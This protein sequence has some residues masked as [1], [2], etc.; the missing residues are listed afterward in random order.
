MKYTLDQQIL[1]DQVQD[2]FNAGYSCAQCVCCSFAAQLNLSQKELYRIS[3][4]FGGGMA[5]GEVCGAVAGAIMV[6]GLKSASRN[7]DTKDTYAK[8]YTY[9]QCHKFMMNFKNHTGSLCCRDLIGFDF[10]KI[11]DNQNIVNFDRNLYKNCSK[12][13]RIATQ[14]L[15]EIIN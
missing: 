14:V 3:A 13:I 12:Y 4:G 9:Q 7:A 5:S 2:L 10:G 11:D 1:I 15:I 8:E 6:I